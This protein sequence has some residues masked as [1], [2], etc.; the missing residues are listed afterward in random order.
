MKGAGK[1][2]P[3][4]H[5][6]QQKRYGFAPGA[7]IPHEGIL[8]PRLFFK[9]ISPTALTAPTAPPP[10]PPARHPARAPRKPARNSGRA[11]TSP[12]PSASK[13]SPISSQVKPAAFVG[14]LFPL[15]PAIRVAAPAPLP[16]A[17]KSAGS[18]LRTSARSASPG[19]GRVSTAPPMPAQRA[20]APPHSRH[21]HAA[22]SP[23]CSAVMPANAAPARHR[24]PPPAPAPARSS[25][26]SFILRLRGDRQHMG[27]VHRRCIRC[28]AILGYCTRLLPSLLEKLACFRCFPCGIMHAPPL[29]PVA[30][31]RQ[32]PRPLQ[33][34]RRLIQNCVRFVETTLQPDRPR[35]LRERLRPRV[36][37]LR[38]RQV[39]P[40]TS[41]ALS[42]LRVIPER[43]ERR[44]CPSL[45]WCAPPYQGNSAP[46]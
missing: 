15:R 42:R 30:D 22:P 40:K 18:A 43:V 12:W 10:R 4:G 3:E 39:R 13:H 33:Q 35:Q 21:R 41:L 29:E 27:G 20:P 17:P 28:A 26:S 14:Q 9:S 7:F 1:Q 8:P 6:K 25:E 45:G 23:G 31:S 19:L 37:P 11:S 2:Q 36:R 5:H 32:R 24:K 46:V 34:R 38:L 44:R 16:A